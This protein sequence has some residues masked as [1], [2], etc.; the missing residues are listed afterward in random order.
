LHQTSLCVKATNIRS[1]IPKILRNTFSEGLQYAFCAYYRP[2]SF[3]QL[4]HKF[5]EIILS[6]GKKKCSGK[7]WL[8]FESTAS[9][10]DTNY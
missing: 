8:F 6:A 3:L 7:L 1:N 4:F 2:S 10:V 5:I 9:F